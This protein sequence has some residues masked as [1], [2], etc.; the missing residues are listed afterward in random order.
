MGLVLGVDARDGRDSKHLLS[1]DF[2]LDFHIERVAT[3]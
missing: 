3:T 1:M 2:P